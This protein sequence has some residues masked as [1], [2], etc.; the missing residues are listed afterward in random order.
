MSQ[1]STVVSHTSSEL[2]VLGLLQQSSR[3]GVPQIAQLHCLTV[4]E[5]K[6]SDQMVSESLLDSE[7]N[8]I[9]FQSSE[10]H[11]AASP[12]SV[13]ELAP[14]RSVKKSKSDHDF[15]L[16]SHHWLPYNGLLFSK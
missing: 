13:S 6:K 14:R 5:V 9:V 7:Q 15:S 4:L 16:L 1:S 12:P 3:D 2:S 11:S 8:P 10:T